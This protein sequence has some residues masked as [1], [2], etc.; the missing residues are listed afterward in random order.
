MGSLPEYLN[1]PQFK[2]DPNN[3]I[4]SGGPSPFN[5]MF[6]NEFKHITRVKLSVSILKVANWDPHL[7]FLWM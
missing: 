4:V 2:W 5:L 6:A 3:N 7:T 1:G